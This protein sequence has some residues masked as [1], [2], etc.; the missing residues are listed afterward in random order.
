MILK[1]SG[2]LITTPLA[3]VAEGV[4]TCGIEVKIH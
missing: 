3:F 4:G 1:V 2:V